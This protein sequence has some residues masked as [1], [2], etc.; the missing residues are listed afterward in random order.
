MAAIKKSLAERSHRW[1]QVGDQSKSLEADLPQARKD[2]DELRK[3]TEELPLLIA[4][5]AHHLGEMRML[6][7]KIR[8]KAKRADS[9]RGRIGAALRGKYGFDSTELIR[10]GFTPR[11]AVKKD[12]MDRQVADESEAANQEP[13]DSD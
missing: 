13:Q 9:I 11:K 4:Q 7:A 5:Q 2:I 3:I 8:A 10:Y 6:T 12:G 1:R